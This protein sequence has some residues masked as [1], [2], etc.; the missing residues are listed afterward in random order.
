MPNSSEPTSYF[1]TKNFYNDYKTIVKKVLKIFK[2]K[3]SFKD[4]Y[5]NNIKHDIPTSTFKGPF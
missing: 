2:S 3:K 5:D 4:D 1:M